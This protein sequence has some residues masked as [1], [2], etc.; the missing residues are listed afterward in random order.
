M[1]NYNVSGDNILNFP[2][3]HIFEPDRQVKCLVSNLLY[4]P[5][6]HSEEQFLVGMI[7]ISVDT[8]EHSIVILSNIE[9][10]LT[11]Q[12]AILTNTHVRELDKLLYNIGYAG[13]YPKTTDKYSPFKY[14]KSFMQDGTSAY[15]I[16]HSLLKKVAFFG[17]KR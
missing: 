5:H 17:N 16:A 12:I 3:S 1:R 10:I 4:C 15:N 2:N 13:L 7:A 9:A 6:P 14:G 8:K 11:S